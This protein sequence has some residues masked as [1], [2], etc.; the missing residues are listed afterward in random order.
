[1][2]FVTLV[3]LLFVYMGAYCVVGIKLTT[4]FDKLTISKGFETGYT[5]L[6][7]VSIE[8]SRFRK[9]VPKIVI[10]NTVVTN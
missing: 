4:V 6:S 7:F 5:R 3:D 8:I 10:G 1:M 2:N 9:L